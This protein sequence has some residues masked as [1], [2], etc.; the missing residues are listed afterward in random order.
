MVELVPEGR[1]LQQLKDKAYVEKY[2]TESQPIYLIGVEF[3]RE[4]RNV[5][6]FA[7]ETV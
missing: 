5:V 6:E 1:A 7:V 3:S 2:R 4:E